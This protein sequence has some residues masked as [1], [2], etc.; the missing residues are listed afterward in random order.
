MGLLCPAGIGHAVNTVKAPQ[1]VSEA[2]V[3]IES[4]HVGHERSCILFRGI[5]DGLGQNLSGQGSAQESLVVG[6]S[7][8]KRATKVWALPWVGAVCHAIS[9]DQVLFDNFVDVLETCCGQRDGSSQLQVVRVVG[10]D[11]A[12]LANQ[13][14]A[15]VDRLRALGDVTSRG[16]A[17]RGPFH[18]DLRA[19]PLLQAMRGPR[20][21]ILRPPVTSGPGVHLLARMASS[22][23]ACKGE[24]HSEG[25]F[26]TGVL[27]VFG[28]P[29][30]VLV[31][32][33]VQ[34]LD[35]SIVHQACEE[36]GGWPLARAPGGDLRF[37]REVAS[38]V[39]KELTMLGSAN[40]DCVVRGELPA[41]QQLRQGVPLAGIR[42]LAG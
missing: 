31:D 34:R 9:I 14:N 38:F 4:V 17:L 8:D 32:R 21:A 5:D 22:K 42:S 11:L 12:R 2:I 23:A 18:A 33:I 35:G 15:L 25:D 40:R 16:V 39:E 26:G 28:P 3:A 29:V 6:A 10:I 30:E 36:H 7:G 37:H 24:Q 1:E 41:L 27:G 13:L 19:Q 20:P